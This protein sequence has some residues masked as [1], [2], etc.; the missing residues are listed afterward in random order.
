M[1]QQSVRSDLLKQSPKPKLKAFP[2]IL[3]GESKKVYTFGGLWNKQHLTDTQ[4][5]NANLSVKG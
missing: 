4:N 5:L 2:L 1:N 3:P